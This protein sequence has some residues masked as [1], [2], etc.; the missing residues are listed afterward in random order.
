MF[1]KECKKCFKCKPETEFYKRSDGSNDGLNSYCISCTKTKQAEY[2]KTEKGRKANLLKVKNWQ[3]NNIDR[4]KFHN[5]K[6]SK[7][8]SQLMDESYMVKRLKG[9]SKY[10]KAA[11]IKIFPFLIEAA[12]INLQIKR[13]LNQNN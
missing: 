3:S 6:S 5:R 8:H 1:M 7:K 10:I 2:R 9:R 4:H 11:E 12:K 13:E